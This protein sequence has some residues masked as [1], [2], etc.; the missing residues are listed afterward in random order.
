MKIKILFVAN[1]H[2]HFKAFHIPY[3]KW[4]KSEGYEVHVAANDGSTLIEEAHKQFNIPINRNPFSWSN[5]K[6]INQLQQIIKKEGYHLVHCH[7]AMGS[8]VARLA[9]KPFKKN[10]LKV[11]Y[12]AHGFHFFKGS[13]KKYWLLYYPVEKY[14]SKFTDAL[15]VINEEDYN[16]V[17]NKMPSIHHLFLIPGV[18]INTRKFE[19]INC[20]E[21]HTL[22][23]KNGYSPNTFLILYIA[24]FIP[25]KNHIFLLSAAK[26]LSKTL[27]NFKIILAGRGAKLEQIKQQSLDL[28]ISQF[29]DFLGF[30]TDIG[31]IICMCDIGVSV[32]KQEGLPMNVAEE[33]YAGKPVVASKI[34]GHTDLIDHLKTGFLFDPFNTT[35]FVNYIIQLSKD[36]QQFENMSKASRIKAQKFEINNCMAQMKIIYKQFLNV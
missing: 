13:S 2:K 14:L 33:M 10:G 19:S 24:E 17:K 36:K 1:I 23:L 5:L 18:G 7:T 26:E 16:L 34:R 20:T 32:S 9:A 11:L 30:R 25:R 35:D 21:T 28:N 29:I 4:L 8:V 27:E 15:I 31:E 6:A 22:K 3:I 12:T